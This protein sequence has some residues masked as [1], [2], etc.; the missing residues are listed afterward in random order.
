MHCQYRS[1]CRYRCS[2]FKKLEAEG[3]DPIKYIRIYSLRNWAKLGKNERLVSE[4]IY[5]H[6]KV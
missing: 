5:I 1:I 2:I 3:I 4:M 6:A